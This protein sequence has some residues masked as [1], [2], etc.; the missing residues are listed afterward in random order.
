M[1]TFEIVETDKLAGFFVTYDEFET[2]TVPD[3][4]GERVSAY[5]NMKQRASSLTRL[6]QAFPALNEDDDYFG[7][8]PDEFDKAKLVDFSRRCMSSVSRELFTKA[9]K[10]QGNTVRRWNPNAN[11]CSLSIYLGLIGIDEAA[12]KEC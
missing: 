7:Q 12:S 5:L 4:T 1:P 10:F 6:S 2:I 11:E 9:R 3:F 8:C